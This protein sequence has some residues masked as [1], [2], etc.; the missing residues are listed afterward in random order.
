VADKVD[1]ST[2]HTN[3]FI[4]AANKFDAA[5]IQEQARTYKK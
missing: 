5:K 1:V 2:V 3:E 4:E